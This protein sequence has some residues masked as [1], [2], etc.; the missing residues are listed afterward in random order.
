[1]ATN[2]TPWYKSKLVSGFLILAFLPFALTYFIL[3]NKKWQSKQKVQ[4][5]AGVWI[6]FFVI[7]GIFSLLQEP[8]PEATVK[9]TTRTEVSQVSNQQTQ[10]SEVNDVSGELNSSS[11]PLEQINQIVLD[12]SGVSP[13]VYSGDEFANETNAPYEVFV[14]LPFDHSVSS[15][16]MAKSLSVEVMKSLYTNDLIRPNI[17]R[18]IVTVPNYLRVSLGASDGVPMVDNNAFNGPT[19]YWNTLEQLG[20]GE[21]E[22][23]SLENR[24][25]G[26]YLAKCSE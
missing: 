16:S 23:G 8:K 5:I 3:K 25:W 9:S 19:V 6:A 17:S 4:Y 2:K 12:K 24:T 21:N 7:S 20:L 1:M 15:C 18:V 10:P 11:N 14:N 26:V 22:T 13:E